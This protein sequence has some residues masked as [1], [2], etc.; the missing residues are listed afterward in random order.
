MNVSNH[1][2]HTFYLILAS[3]LIGLTQ[4]QMDMVANVARYHRKS[5]PKMQHKPYEDLAPKQ[6]LTISKLAAILRLADALDHE[7][8]STVDEV[9][10]EFK[11]PRFI[12][13]MKG[14]GD[15][16]LE[17]WALVG[18]ARYVRER[19]RRQ[20]RCGGSRKLM[21]EAKMSNKKGRHTRQTRR[22]RRARWFRKIHS[23]VSAEDD[24]SNWK[25]IKSSSPSGTH[26]PIV[27]KATRKGK[28]RQLLTPTT[29][30]LIHCTDFAD[31][32][33]RQILPLLNAGYIVLADRYIFTAFARDAVRA[34]TAAGFENFTAM[35]SI[36]TLRSIFDV[37]L[38]TALARI[39]DGRTR[40]KYH[41]AGMD[42]GYSKDPYES[43]RIFQGK[44][45]QEYRRMV[46]E[47]DFIKIDATEPPDVQQ[48]KVRKILETSIDLPRY[49]WHG[50]LFPRRLD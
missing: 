42:M 28:K 19:L 49:R 4:L 21:V 20:R 9:K 8:A 43:F 36:P 15:M 34:V 10:V 3:P 33:E 26:P 50:P 18:E 22:R 5:A 48:T 46:R 35:P 2:K 7:H 38:K 47:Y 16:L 32:Y 31:R 45:N 12:F 27:R 23:G 13:R 39:L 40:V 24:G 41:E 25:A 30:S 17:K 44:I 1:H 14:K 29:F 11:R 37:P 6:R